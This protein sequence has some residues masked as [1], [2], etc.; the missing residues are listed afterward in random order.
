MERKDFDGALG[1]YTWL[2]TSDGSYT[3]FS[4]HFN[5]AC[6]SEG[7]AYAETLHNYVY[8]CRI[9][10]RSHSPLKIFEVGF[11]TGLGLECT[12]REL[13]K[14]DDS[15]ALEYYSCELD[16]ELAKAS[17]QSL[18]FSYQEKEFSGII[19]LEVAKED[20]LI[21]VYLGDIREN[22][23]NLIK[24]HHIP[25]VHAIYQDAFSPKR[26][27]RLWTYEWFKDLIKLGDKETILSTY[28]SSKAIWKSM[29]A[30]GWG[31]EY[32]EGYYPKK[33][34]TRAYPYRESTPE[35]NKLLD[36]SPMEMFKDEHFTKNY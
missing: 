14:K 17:L 2:K 12:L 33:W 13:S 7:G 21:R 34:S 9:L 25:T 19:Y 24:N 26:N 20:L 6:H 27:P 8:G 23:K 32:V 16:N 18:N 31:L 36:K 3:L 10:E 28:C 11:G 4:K 29:K 30:S 35:I 1:T 22:L 15:R 5:E